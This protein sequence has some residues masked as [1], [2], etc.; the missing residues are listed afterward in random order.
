MLKMMQYITIITNLGEKM[1]RKYFFK[2]LKI[3]IILFVFIIISISL[4]G[5]TS[6]AQGI[7]DTYKPIF[8][9]EGEETCFPIDAQYH[10]DNSIEKWVDEFLPGTYFYD[11]THGTIKD[12]GV[13]NHYKSVMDSYGY[14]VFYRT[15]EHFATSSTVIQY[16]MFYAFNKGELNQHEGDWEMVQVVVDDF[17][18]PLWVAYSQHHSGQ[19]ASW[20]QVEKEGNHIKVYVARGSHA[21]Y[22]RSYSGKLGIASDIVGANGKVLNYNEYTLENLEDQTW[23]DFEGR[24]GEVAENEADAIEASILGKAGPPGPKFREEGIM[25][26]DPIGWGNSIF[27]SNDML[28]TLEW[29]VYNFVLIFVVKSNN[30]SLTLGSL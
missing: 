15:Y 24:W 19:K 27:E 13:I 28:F 8:Y 17:D 14:T 20:S 1:R 18:G 25:W 29:L 30:R 6:S 9:F 12:D 16:W 2:G 22:L 7:A 4:G 11:N 5:V 3:N 23:I 10:L 21:N 26:D